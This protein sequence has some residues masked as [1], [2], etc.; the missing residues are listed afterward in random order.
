[1]HRNYRKIKPNQRWGCHSTGNV[2]KAQKY[3]RWHWW[4]QSL[5]ASGKFYVCKLQNIFEITL[6]S[7]DAPNC[8]KLSGHSGRILHT[9]WK[10]SEQSG[11]FPDSL[12]N[13]R[14]VW[15]VVRQSA[16]FPDNLRLL[17]LPLKF[18]GSGKC[19]SH[20]QVG[21]ARSWGQEGRGP[22]KL[23]VFFSW[24]MQGPAWCRS[25]QLSVS[26][27]RLGVPSHL[28]LALLDSMISY[29]F[30]IRKLIIN[31]YDLFVLCIYLSSCKYLSCTPGLEYW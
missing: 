13:F 8:Q 7:R 5:C 21:S 18:C 14:T 24:C 1:M 29:D 27:L 2:A 22:P 20:S 10:V 6:R 25:M 3:M 19:E 9:I 30:M 4:P 23:L 12:E 15:K 16:K 17:S 26:K 28:M 11:K 31:I